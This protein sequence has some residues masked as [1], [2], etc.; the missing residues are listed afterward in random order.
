[1][2]ATELVRY[3]LDNVGHHLSMTFEGIDERGMDARVAPVGKTAREI[4]AHLCECYR[5][6]L[7]V[8]RTGK[9]EWGSFRIEETSWPKLISLWTQMREEAVA[10]CLAGDEGRLKV[11]VD[12]VMLHDEYHVGQMC[13]IRLQADPNW[14]SDSIYHSPAQEGLS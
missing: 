1:M 6:A 8:C 9:H 4:V 13:L 5:A 2:N 11:A 14:D 3:G 7:D 12:Y 10:E